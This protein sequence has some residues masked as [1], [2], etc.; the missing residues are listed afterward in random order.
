MHDKGDG[1]PHA[2]IMLTTR[3]FHEDGTWM[4]KS[5]KEYILDEHGEKIRLPSGEYKSRKVDTVDWNR[6]EKIEEWRERYEHITNFHLEQAGLDVR[7]HAKSYERQGLDKTSMVHMGHFAHALEQQGIETTVGTINRHIQAE[8]QQREILKQQLEVTL[9]AIEQE[10][11]RQAAIRQK[12]KRTGTDD[13]SPPPAVSPMRTISYEEMFK[14]YETSKKEALKK[15]QEE[16]A[17]TKQRDLSSYEQKFVRGGRRLQRSARFGPYHRRRM[18]HPNWTKF[19]EGLH[20]RQHRLYEAPKPVDWAQVAKELEEK[21]VD[22]KGLAERRE[23]DFEDLYKRPP[24]RRQG[25][26]HDRERSH[27]HE[28]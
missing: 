15:L 26:D 23:Q 19:A 22:W 25:P 12:T 27:D 7:I 14:I 10:H 3:P 1:N 21:R 8:N 6:T 13:V 17:T 2:H 18:K 11:Q 28:R 16:A 9:S 4:A 24:P 20:A 5:K